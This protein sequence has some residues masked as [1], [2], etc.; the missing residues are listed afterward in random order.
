MAV[1]LR[2]RIACVW[3]ELV[4]ALPGRTLCRDNECRGGRYALNFP[5]VLALNFGAGTSASGVEAQARAT[6]SRDSPNAQRGTVPGYAS[7]PR[8]NPTS[9]L[10]T[11]L[12]LLQRRAKGDPRAGGMRRHPPEPAPPPYGSAPQGRVSWGGIIPEYV[13]LHAAAQSNPLPA[14]PLLRFGVPGFLERPCRARVR[15]PRLSPCLHERGGERHAVG[16]RAGDVDA[17]RGAEDDIDSTMHRTFAG[18]TAVDLG[19]T[20]CSPAEGAAFCAPY[21]FVT[22]LP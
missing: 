8:P 18:E 6:P 15:P 20:V 1:F 11:V 10:R 22:S 14:R 2:E 4:V 21:T 3:R 9:A 19:C 12:A 13:V 16:R 5:H 7:P 17:H